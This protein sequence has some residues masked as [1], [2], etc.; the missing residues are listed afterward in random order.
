MAP[1]ALVQGFAFIRW[2]RTFA[3][4]AKPPPKDGIQSGAPLTATH[5]EHAPD[6]SRQPYATDG[7]ARKVVPRIVPAHASELPRG[8]ELGLDGNLDRRE[9]S[10]DVTL[11]SVALI[12]AVLYAIRAGAPTAAYEVLMVVATGIALRAGRPTGWR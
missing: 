6:A 7:L 3:R 4:I 9:L 10:P 11:C 8:K 1:S 5:Q 12:A 2:S